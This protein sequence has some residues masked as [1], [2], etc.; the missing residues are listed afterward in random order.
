[1]NVLLIAEKL[2]WVGYWGRHLRTS[3]YRSIL[4]YQKV[5]HFPGTFHLGRK[6]R[7]WT[8]INRMGI[9]FGHDA[10]DIMPRTFI[11]PRDR[12][13]L[14][15]KMREI[16]ASQKYIL[17]PVII[18]VSTASVVLI[19]MGALFPSLLCPWNSNY[20]LTQVVSD[21]E[22]AVCYCATV[23]HAEVSCKIYLLKV[24]STAL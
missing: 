2:F 13:R 24:C 20:N 6:D 10:F 12:K 1:M 7:L 11:L 22:K 17:K 14:K 19:R 21:S 15:A 9:R 23:R 18:D 16:G 8:N 3:S 5:N 4:P